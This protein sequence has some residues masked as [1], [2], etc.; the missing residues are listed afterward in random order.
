MLTEQHTLERGHP[1]EQRHILQAGTPIL[2]GGHHIDASSSQSCRDGR[3]DVHIHI[4]PQH[5]PA[6][7]ARAATSLG[8]GVWWWRWCSAYA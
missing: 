2:L 6:C 5:Y 3:L 4:Q 8:C 7:R 1:L